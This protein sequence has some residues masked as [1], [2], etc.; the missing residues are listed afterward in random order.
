MNF[1]WTYYVICV[2]YCFTQLIQRYRQDQSGGLYITPGLD[3]IVVMCL[4]WVLAPVDFFL[5]WMRLY[6][7]AEE[8]RR[9][10]NR[11]K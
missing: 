5:T 10:H 6:K 1:F 7:G 3:A 2:L 8:A 11:I 4:A 9:K